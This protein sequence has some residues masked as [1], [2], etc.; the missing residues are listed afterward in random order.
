VSEFRPGDRVAA[1]HEMMA[2]HGSFAEYAIA[3]QHTTFRIPDATTFEEAAAVPLAAMTSALA[4]YRSLA[5]PDP[6]SAETAKLGPTPLVI[7]G[8]SSAVGIYAV[9]L[10]LRGNIHPLICVA[11]RASDYVA[12][13]LDPSKGDVVVDYRAGNA[14]VV[15]GV[16]EALKGY[17]PVKHVVDAISEGGSIENIGEVLKRAGEKDGKGGVKG[18]VTFVLGEKEVPQGVEQNFTMVGDV[19][20]NE[21]QEAKDFGYVYFRYFAKGLSEG[22]LK[23]QRTEVRPGGLGGIQAGLQDLKDGKASAVKYIFRIAETEG[24]QK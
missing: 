14:A 6:W 9:Q 5:L 4:L 7:Y 24:A 15:D 16:V 8:A 21:M 12:S 22:W 17:P 19:H 3:W 11:G 10:A 13:F 18:K 23:G 20:N 1:F 2:P